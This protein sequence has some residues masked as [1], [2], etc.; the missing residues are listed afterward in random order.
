MTEGPTHRDL[1][2]NNSSSWGHLKALACCASR[3]EGDPGDHF[4]PR[5][6]QRTG[7]DLYAPRGPNGARKV[8]VHPSSF[9]LVHCAKVAVANTSQPR[10]SNFRLGP[11]SLV[12][13]GRYLQVLYEHQGSFCSRQRQLCAFTQQ[14]VAYCPYLAKLKIYFPS[15]VPYK[16]SR[17]SSS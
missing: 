1:C 13:T 5:H 10:S 11:K 7:I 2:F 16:G 12:H 17:Q 8:P 15:R 3:V 9:L 4:D 6:D 14:E